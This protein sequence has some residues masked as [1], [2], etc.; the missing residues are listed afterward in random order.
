MAATEYTRRALKLPLRDV[1]GGYRA[2]RASTLR[3][4][5]LHGSGSAGTSSR[6]ILRTGRSNAAMSSPRYRSNSSSG[7]WATKMNQKIVSR[8]SGG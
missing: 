2:F 8:P 4:L 6:W 3:S 7:R 1:T 5:D